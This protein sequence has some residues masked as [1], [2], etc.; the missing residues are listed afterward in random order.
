MPKIHFTTPDDK[1]FEFELSKERAT[2][3]RA[4]DNDFVVPDGSVSSHH[5]E[6]MLK[7]DSLDIKD[8][9]STNG[10]HYDGQRVEHALIPSGGMFRLG[11]VKG[12]HK[13][14]EESVV[15]TAGTSEGDVT[16]EG[17]YLSLP[18]AGGRSVISGLGAT[19]CPVHMRV[20]F[21]PKEKKKDPVGSFIIGLAAIGVILCSVAA[22]MIFKMVA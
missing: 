7:G 2:I 3:G 11:N 13:G 5:A 8:L 19:E 17:E 16:G 21:G 20:G 12:M 10:T 22:L 9:G 6:F 4:D 15:D 14:G 1:V 18:S